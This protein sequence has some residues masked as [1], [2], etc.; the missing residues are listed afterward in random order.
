MFMVTADYNYP[1]WE[2]LV[3]FFLQSRV[4]KLLAWAAGDWTHNLSTYD[5]SA[6]VKIL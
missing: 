6:S 5:L 3:D 4:E 1:D 2:R